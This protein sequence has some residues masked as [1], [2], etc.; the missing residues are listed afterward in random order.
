MPK[1]V[2][3]ATGSLVDWDLLRISAQSGNNVAKEVD[4]VSAPTQAT[5]RAQ[6]AKMDAARKL[7]DQMA[8]E[9]EA[10]STQPTTPTKKKSPPAVDRTAEPMENPTND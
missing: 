6:R 4:I 1:M 5:R 2:R 7:L 9:V 10:A 8:A 3:T